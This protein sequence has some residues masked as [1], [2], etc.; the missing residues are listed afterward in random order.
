MSGGALLLAPWTIF[1]QRVGE[2]GRVESESSRNPSA[3]FS[4][5]RRRE[6]ALVCAQLFAVP[7]LV[8]LA[9]NLI[10]VQ[11]NVRYTLPC[12][13]P[14]YLLVARGLSLPRALWL[15]AALVVVVVAYSG[16]ALR[17]NYFIP[18]KENYRDGLA[19]LSDRYE[20]NDA[21]I[22]APWGRPPREWRIYGYDK[23]HPK[24]TTTDVQTV[25]RSGRPPV[26]W[27]V[28]YHRVPDAARESRSMRQRLARA[29][30]RTDGARFH[31][32]EVDRL[33]VRPR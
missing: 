12:L 7:L 33:E 13:A 4:I 29:Y 19:W 15:R 32:V 25:V 28:S 10:G 17:A 31:W 24:L 2:A 1:G 14:Y 22:F 23:V 21:V 27:L 8:I 3:E 5:L 20:P 18:Y 30:R 9:V 16:A 11:Y 26:V 6:A